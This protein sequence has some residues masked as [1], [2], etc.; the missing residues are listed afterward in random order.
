MWNI[1][2]YRLRISG[3]SISITSGFCGGIIKLNLQFK[4]WVGM[5]EEEGH[6]VIHYNFRA[7][8]HSIIKEKGLRFSSRSGCPANAKSLALVLLQMV[9]NYQALLCTKQKAQ[10]GFLLLQE[11]QH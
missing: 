3:F 1:R 4:H 5:H 10:S 7:I 8:A 9:K 6:Y 11:R 2:K